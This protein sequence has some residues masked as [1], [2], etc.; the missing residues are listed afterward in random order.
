MKW[1]KK[2]KQDVH[3]AMEEEQESVRIVEV[4]DIL[5]IRVS[6]LHV[7]EEV[8]LHVIIVKVQEHMKYINNMYSH[9]G[10]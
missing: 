1:Q 4:R 3:I 8:T 7:E 5:R 9:C 2:S 10:D 6:V